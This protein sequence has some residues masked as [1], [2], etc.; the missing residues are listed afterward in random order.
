MT[1]IAALLILA[2][3]DQFF[4]MPCVLGCLLA[5][6]YKDRPALFHSSA[7]KR[8]VLFLL[9]LYMCS[10]PTFTVGAEGIYFQHDF[11]QAYVIYHTMGAS[12]LVALI[13]MDRSLLAKVMN[14]SVFQWLGKYSMGIYIIHYSL[15]VSIIAWGYSIMPSDW[16][17]PARTLPLFIVYIICL[18]MAAMPIQ[19]IS[20]KIFNLLDQMYCCIF[21][22]SF[23]GIVREAA[24]E[25][26]Q[27]P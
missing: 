27:K 21:T 14:T 3:V 9:A 18:M 7:T 15:L 6:C 10:Y 5:Y 26:N 2:N 23:N 4:Y 11:S 24:H 16:P 8:A 25:Q 20:V 1:S 13:L 17:Y 19:A 12:M 22:N